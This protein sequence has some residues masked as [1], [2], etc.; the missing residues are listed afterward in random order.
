[1]THPTR[2]A[3]ITTALHALRQAQG[4]PQCQLATLREHGSAALIALLERE[5][6]LC[7]IEDEGATS[8]MVEAIEKAAEAFTEPEELKS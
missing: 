8:P 1:M 4:H 2:V 3:R 6:R 7:L 5:L